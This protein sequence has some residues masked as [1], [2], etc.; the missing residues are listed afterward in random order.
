MPLRLRAPRCVARTRADLRSRSFSF[1]TRSPIM[2]RSSS[3]CFS[4][5]PPVL[6]SEPRWRSRWVHPRTRRVDRCSSRASSTCSL[7]SLVRARCAKMSRITSVRSK[8]RTS[9]CS[10]ESARS[11]LRTCAADRAWSKTTD[12]ASCSR[13]AT[14]ISSTLPEPA[15]VFASGRSR[16]PRITSA[17]SAPALSTRRAA[18]SALSPSRPGP[19]S[20][21]TRIARGRSGF[22]RMLKR[23]RYRARRHDRG[24]GVLVHH[25]RHGVLEEDHVLVERFD[26]PLELDAVDQ[27]DRHRHMLLAQRI[28]ERVLKQ[29]ALV[30]HCCAPFLSAGFPVYAGPLPASGLYCKAATAATVE[31]QSTPSLVPV[32]HA[33]SGSNSAILPQY[34]QPYRRFEMIFLRRLW[35]SCFSVSGRLRP[36]NGL[37]LERSSMRM[38][39]PFSLNTLRKVFSR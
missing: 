7:P 34:N 30:A 28:E 13:M 4:P 1:F 31:G 11:R 32:E 35:E 38:G 21:L 39:V 5:G 16:R 19:M 17:T 8:T 27:V 22:R 12:C 14:W 36:S 23:Y 9:R 37:V 33:G 29:L 26:L 24:D 15:K 20:R 10:S 6:P 3:I 18:S 2:R 25:L